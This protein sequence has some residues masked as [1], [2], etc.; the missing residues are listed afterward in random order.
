MA[1][2]IVVLGGRLNDDGT[3]RPV[4]RSRVEK[5]VELFKQGVAP[6][7]IMSGKWTDQLKKDPVKTEARAMKEYAEEL[8]VPEHAILVEEQSQNTIGNAYYTKKI[9]AKRA[10]K[11][12]VVVT[13][14]F[15]LKR[16]LYLFKIGRAHV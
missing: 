8:W 14:D 4:L 9:L 12:I 2:A 1:D 13:S 10:W 15:H 16:S 5:A 3:L 11:D 6:V 7:V